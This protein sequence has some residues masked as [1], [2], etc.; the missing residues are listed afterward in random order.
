M[1]ALGHPPSATDIRGSTADPSGPSRPVADRPVRSAAVASL[2]AVADWPVDQ[3]AA[4]W[5]DTRGATRRPPTTHVFALASVTKLLSAYATLVAVE[6]RTVDLDEPTGPPGST[7]RHLLAHAS[8]L[9]FDSGVLVPPERKRIY[10]NT[11]FEALGEHWPG[12]P[13]C[14]SATTSARRWSNP[15]AWWPPTSAT[16][17]LPTARGPRSRTSSASWP[18]LRP[19][20]DRPVH[21]GR[22]HD[23]RVPG[24][25]R[26]APRLRAPAPERLG[27][28]LRA[29]GRQVAALDRSGL[30]GGHL[31]PLRC[32]GDV[33]LG[34][35]GRRRR[36]R[37]PHRS[38][39]RA[40]APTPGRRSPTRSSPSPAPPEPPGPRRQ[41][42][43][44]GS[45][46]GRV[47]TP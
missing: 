34:R 35:S 13:G 31:R 24:A 36:T 22:R 42:A 27:P 3:A 47:T 25:G 23:R 30:L 19:H 5:V 12:P 4:A 39:V 6:E 43:V 15:S 41:G 8:G 10:S 1:V 14:R 33:P 26:R 11:G 40:G 18:E 32:G 45:A 17:P 28:R 21:P 20:A 38:T 9:G 37:C 2:D 16:A 46:D 7:V 44:Y 29:Q